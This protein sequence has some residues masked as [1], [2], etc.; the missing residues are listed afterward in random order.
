MCIRDRD[1]TVTSLELESPQTPAP[2]LAQASDSVSSNFGRV[3]QR[4]ILA[5]ASLEELLIPN[6]V[7]ST[8]Q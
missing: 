2:T 4:Q 6:D 7:I 8:E 1:R 3:F 5:V